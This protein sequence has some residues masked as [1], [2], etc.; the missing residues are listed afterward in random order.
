M[1]DDVDYYCQQDTHDKES[2]DREVEG[3]SVSLYYYITGE[4]AQERDMLAE[5][6]Y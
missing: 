6:Q 1:Q 4:L 5:N 3:E 2:N